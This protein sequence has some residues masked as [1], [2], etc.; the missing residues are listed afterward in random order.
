MNK[1]HQQHFT[2]KVHLCNI[3][4][5]GDI[6]VYIKILDNKRSKTCMTW[7]SSLQRNSILWKVT[8]K[9]LYLC[10]EQFLLK[11]VYL[12]FVWWLEVT[13]EQYK[14]K[15]ATNSVNISIL[16]LKIGA[17][18]YSHCA[19]SQAWNPTS[20]MKVDYVHTVLQRESVLRVKLMHKERNKKT[21]T[22]FRQTLLILVLLDFD[23]QAIDSQ[24][25]T[26]HRGSPEKQSITTKSFSH[27]SLIFFMKG[28]N[29]F[30]YISYALAT[31]LSG[32]DR[33]E[34][35]RHS[36]HEQMGLAAE[37]REFNKQKDTPN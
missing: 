5:S 17:A 6:V 31:C 26:N 7:H 32:W 14:K 22:D 1:Q 3:W 29:L 15:T 16:I 30:D 13:I 33:T 28:K 2:S 25:G 24:T 9:L 23:Q 27:Y 4:S 35:R 20:T 21:Q 34:S 19:T 12:F 8:H 11:L 10:T 18:R 36:I 37:E